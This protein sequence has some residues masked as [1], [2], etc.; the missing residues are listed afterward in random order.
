MGGRIKGTNTIFFIHPSKIPK[1][2]K[3]TYARFVCDYRPQK[4]EK[5][6]TRLTVGGNL[7]DYPGEVSTWTAD[8]T[9]AK[10]LFNSVISDVWARFM[11]LDIK[12]YY[13]GTPLDR[14]EYLR[15]RWED[16]PDEI[17]EEYN[18]HELVVDGAIYVEIRK[19][20]YGL[21]QAGILAN[22]LLKERLAKHGYYECARTHGLWRHKWRPIVFALVVDDFGVK[23]V[24]EEHARHLYAALREHYEV[25]CDW[26]GALFVGIKLNWDYQN[27]SVT[28][29]MPGYIEKALKRFQHLP[30]SDQNIPRTLHRT[31]R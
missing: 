16:V 17:R 4:T 30:P 9:T 7:I 24:G 25:T 22:K 8:I 11:C 29:S 27:R 12:N 23:Y 1:G 21:P 14:Y 28:M 18:L 19:G 31:N 15:I 20:M 2:R 5:E 10:L 13:L 3:A 26:E 6:R